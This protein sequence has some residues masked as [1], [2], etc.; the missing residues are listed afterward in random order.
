MEQVINLKSDNIKKRLF[1]TL[2][3]ISSGFLLLYTYFTVSAIMNVAERRRIEGEVMSLRTDSVSLELA[4]I[5]KEGEITIEK[6][7][8]LGFVETSRQFAS[9]T[10]PS[11]AVSI[12]SSSR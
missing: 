1:W 8:N 5:Q 7:Y 9:R 3:V 10:S 4:Y 6:A 12:K 2:V 11:V